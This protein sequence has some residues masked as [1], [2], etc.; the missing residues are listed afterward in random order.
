MRVSALILAMFFLGCSGGGKKDTVEGGGGGGGEGGGGGPS[1]PVTLVSIDADSGSC[2]AVVRGPGGGE[3]SHAAAS[4]LCPGGA[5]DASALV[6]KAVKLEMGAA[7]MPDS[8]LPS[9]EDPCRDIAPPCGGDTSG[10]AEMVI[11][12]SGA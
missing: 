6:G 11:G 5:R 12:I 4:E 9:G 2:V 3:N 10:G 1:G 8:K 7:P